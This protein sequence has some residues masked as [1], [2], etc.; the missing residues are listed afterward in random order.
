MALAYIAIAVM[1]VP[2]KVMGTTPLRRKVILLGSLVLFSP[3]PAFMGPIK[4]IQN[5]LGIEPNAWLL[6]GWFSIKNKFF[7]LIEL[8]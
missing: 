8:L 4:P 7:R 5:I 3:V 2:W 6:A 1:A